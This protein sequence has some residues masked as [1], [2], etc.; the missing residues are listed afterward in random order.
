MRRRLLKT[1][2]AWSWCGDRWGSGCG[3]GRSGRC[4]GFSS[5]QLLLRSVAAG[6]AEHGLT[7]TAFYPLAVEGDSAVHVMQLL[8]LIFSSKYT[9]M[10][11][12]RKVTLVQRIKSV[13]H[14][15][16]YCTFPQ[17]FS[18]TTPIRIL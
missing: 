4:E 18:V 3:R 11:V 15:I 2:P 9:S 6:G 8:K 16:S 12:S 14:C 7:H 1:T 13:K 10:G 17:L 5:S